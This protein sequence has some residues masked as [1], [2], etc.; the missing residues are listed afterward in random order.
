MYY[1]LRSVNIISNMQFPDTSRC[2][3]ML[4]K[5][6]LVMLKHKR[7]GNPT[8][9]SDI[10][11]LNEFTLMAERN[12]RLP[13]ASKN[14]K[15]YETIYFAMS[16]LREVKNPKAGQ[17]NVTAAMGK[18][19]NILSSHELSKYLFAEIEFELNKP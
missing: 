7:V 17:E 19:A 9:E 10:E 15:L 3:S 16:Y 4:K 6:E 18:I 12:I 5:I 1:V 2:S 8:K 13:D 11:L 14:N